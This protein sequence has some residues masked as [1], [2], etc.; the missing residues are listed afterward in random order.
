MGDRC[1]NEGT[2]LV[3]REDDCEAVIVRRFTEFDLS[4]AP[5]L[6]YY[7]NADYHRIDGDR[8]PQLVS[9]ELLHILGVREA[10]AAA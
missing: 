5:L 6:E 3:Q 4:C 9:A 2:V 1:E 10:R 8:D 7:A